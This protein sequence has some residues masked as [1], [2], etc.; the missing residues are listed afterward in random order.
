VQDDPGD[1]ARLQILLSVI[2]HG[3]MR[4]GEIFSFL[5]WLIDKNCQQAKMQNALRSWRYDYKRL[6]D[7]GENRIVDVG[8]IKHK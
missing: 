1:H 4:K 8:A 7:M 2:N 5:N 6:S 3:L